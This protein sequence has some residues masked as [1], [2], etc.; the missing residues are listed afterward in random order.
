MSVLAM[1]NVSTLSV[2]VLRMLS[3]RMTEVLMWFNK[4]V[5]IAGNKVSYKVVAVVCRWFKTDDDAVVGVRKF[6]KTRLQQLEAI[7]VIRE[8]KRLHEFCAIRRYGWCKVIE[9]GNVNAYVDHEVVLPFH[10]VWYRESH[11]RLSS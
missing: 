3:L 8:F 10:K 6:N 1:M 4:H 11:Q 2:L 9:F 5:V 7:T